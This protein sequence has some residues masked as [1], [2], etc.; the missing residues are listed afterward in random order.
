[1]TKDTTRKVTKSR[2]AAQAAGRK[3]LSAVLSIRS[4]EVFQRL[5][6]ERGEK[7][8]IE[9]ALDALDREQRGGGLDVPA[10]LEALAADLRAKK[11]R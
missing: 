3:R 11:R 4:T 2:Q 5:K 9:D 10:V 1:M 6:G 7:E 8:V